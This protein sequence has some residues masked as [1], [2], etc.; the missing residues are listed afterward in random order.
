VTENRE[1]LPAGR[2]TPI[3][4]EGTLDGR[5][6]QLKFTERGAQRSGTGSLT[7]ELTDEGTLRGT[8]TSDAASARGTSVA[9]RAA[10]QSKRD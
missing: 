1:S 9:Q 7:L 4:V 3:A 6:L 8:C 2:R 10:S 5:R